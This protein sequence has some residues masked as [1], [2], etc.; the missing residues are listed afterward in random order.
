M[1]KYAAAVLP[2]LLQGAFALNSLT[3][4]TEAS[5][6]GFDIAQYT[7][8]VTMDA[9]MEPIFNRLVEFQQ[10]TTKLVPG[11]A[12]R[13]EVSKDNTEYTFYLRKNVAFHDTEYFK[14]TRTLN[15]DDV[16]WS[17]RRM[18]DSSHPWN[19]LAQNGFPYAS[20]MGFPDLIKSVEKTDPYTVKITLKHP[21]APFLADL[22]MG[23]ASIYS[24]EYADQLLKNGTP[25]KLNQEPIG[26]GP[27]KLVRYQKDALI[28]YQAFDKYFRGKPKV[29]RLNFSITTDPSVRIQKLLANECQIALYPRPAEILPLKQNKAIK[30]IG[31]NEL[32]T[33]YLAFNTQKPGL[34]NKLV[35]QALSYAVDKKSYNK[36]LF[37]DGGALTAKNPYPPAMWSYNNST[38]EYDYNPEK[39]KQLLKQAGLPNGLQLTI[40]T[41]NS[42]GPNNPN[43]KVGAELLQ[44]DWAKVGVKANIVT[45]EWGELLKRARKGEHDVFVTGWTGDNGDPDNFLS[46]QLSCAAKKDGSNFARYCDQELDKLLDKA[47]AQSG[48]KE[49]TTLYQQAQVRIND[50]APWLMLSHP[51]TW[52]ATRSNISGYVINPL[53]T[54]NYW[55]VT[56]TP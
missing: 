47:K 45:M 14:P 54:N 39:A 21:E 28:R 22:A 40:W 29:D 18:T 8:I 48:I 19:K 10:G 17:F 23:F 56:T 11:L 4:C 53:G 46:P 27:F 41:R 9:S 26:T 33:S 15:A 13:W 38:K 50:N 20:S 55:R 35:R 5:P 34:S 16:I 30:V 52:V 44:A 12:E 2:L 25:E 32:M 3:V 31:S 36:A 24:A 42:G 1:K 51:T 43:P 49:R 7:A 6:E 37:G